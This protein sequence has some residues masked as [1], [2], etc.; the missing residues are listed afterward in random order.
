M[1][2]SPELI[3]ASSLFWPQAARK[4]AQATSRHQ[5]AAAG[6][7]GTG[8]DYSAIRV[9]VPTFEHAQLFLKALGQEIAGNFIPPRINTMF[10]WLEMLPPVAGVPRVTAGSERLM[11][12]Y[13]ELRQHAWLKKLFTARRNT[14]L[15]PLAQTLLT[16]SDELT[17]ALLPTVQAGKEDVQQR[18]HAALAQM[19]PPTQKILSEEAQL[20]WT[21]WQSQLDDSDAAVQRFQKLM[22][23]AQQASENIV[24]ISPTA[25]DAMEDAFLAAYA[26][27]RDVLPVLLDWRDDALAQPYAPA[28]PSMIE[29]VPDRPQQFAL[30]VADTSHIRL[31][32]TAS[33]EEEAQQGAQTIIH[34]LQA[35]KQHI[36]VI[37]QDRVVARRIRALLER[38]QVFVADETG[39]KLSTT[40]AAAAIAAWFEV[41][42][43]RADTIAL[44]DLLKS[45][46]I[47][48][49]KRDST[50]GQEAHEA[51]DS[52]KADQVMHVELALRKANVLGGWDAILASLG[53]LPAERQWIASLSRQ[54]AAFTARRS[55]PEWSAGTLQALDALNMLAAMQA[56]NAGAQ[57]VKLLQSLSSDCQHMEA[58]FSFAEWRAFINLQLESAPFIVARPDQRVMMLPLNGARL[59]SFDAVL[60]VGADATHLPSQPQEVLFFTNTVRRECGLVTREARQRQQLRDFAE[61]LLSNAEVVL[62]WQGHLDGEHNP[63]SPWLAQLNLT[64]QRS[65]QAPLARHAAVIPQQA[66][67]AIVPVQPR[68]RAPQLTPATLSA[69]GYG[70]LVACPYQFFAGRML[71]LAAIDTLSDMPEKKDYGDWLHAI[72]KKYHD[73]LLERQG[74]VDD[75]VQ[76][77][78]D[79]SKEQFDRI[80][81]HSPAALGYSV[82][83]E[84]VIPAYVAWATEREQGGWHFEL[85]EAWR[86]RTLEWQD[87][88]VTLRGRIDR[89]D[90]NGL[91]EYA[92]LD[93]KTKTQTAL[94]KRLKD[95]EDHQLPFYGLLADVPVTTAS[96]VALEM[97]RGKT[98]AVEARDFTEWTEALETAV[99]THM[100][101]IK[102]GAPLPAQGT[103]SVCQYCDMRGL[104]RKG[105]W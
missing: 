61:L 93:Y 16:L 10:A 96:Y 42:A 55:L 94:S 74:E 64:L 22:Q 40:R 90:K 44:L 54:A 21:I 51:D 53:N 46:Y 81:Q 77:L 70:S 72:L 30:E 104:C 5:W 52:D 59:R 75:G 95:G 105:A 73:A 88:A 57:I 11:G 89:L 99:I 101:A 2:H 25:P 66:L 12:L 36:A 102:Q 60:L 100:Q 39:W 92:V 98:G 47:S 23:I 33:L 14:D 35:G 62:S 76:L 18:W 15:L 1:R 28:W 97:D 48:A 41:I 86:E 6:A 87:G 69:S 91:G 43:T 38:A 37:A 82:R 49:G 31:C 85:G 3:A 67:R 13:A 50:P 29:T 103:E 17:L 58:P 27:K 4:F 34:W 71:G 56:D 24:W 26:K 78:R 45:P 83:W 32:E 80:L 79:I 68:P 84:K 63:V 8:R 20:V 65:G 7:A 9:I 19:P